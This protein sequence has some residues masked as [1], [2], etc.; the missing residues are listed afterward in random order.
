MNENHNPWTILSGKEQYDNNWINVMEYQVINPT[1]G[2]GIYGKIHFKN[3]A[4]GIVALDA[5]TNIYLIGQYRFPIDR[6]SWEIPEGGGPV[7]TDPLASAQR[8][9]LEEAGLKA[10]RWKKV[11]ELY[12]SNSVSD[13]YAIVYLATG[14]SEHPAKPEETEELVRKK[15]PF[16]NAYEMI[17][18][19]EITDALSVLAIQK[20]RLMMLEKELV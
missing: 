20:I 15:I 6:Y 17:K 10:D 11:L 18:T 14:L 16:D 8:E 3:I 1:G 7:G 19:G 4:I 2:R 13:E 5:E 9:L 12:L